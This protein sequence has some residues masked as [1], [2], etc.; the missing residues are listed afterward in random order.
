MALTN[1]ADE[2]RGV[3]RLLGRLLA[4]DVEPLRAE[5]MAGRRPTI[6][7]KLFLD[8]VDV[9]L[10]LIERLDVG[11]DEFEDREREELQYG[12]GE[13]WMR[14]AESG[15]MDEDYINH[16]LAHLGAPGGAVGPPYVRALL[17]AISL[18]DANNRM[19]LSLGCPE[20]VGLIR[21][22]DEVPHAIDRM[23]AVV[24]R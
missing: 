7:E 21:A 13:M 8:L 23:R 20:Y 4:E 19:A 10:E 1:M 5:V 2:T 6:D 24:G 11:A 9:I 16:V 17:Q 15:R 22:F 3:A 12:T 18:S 14:V